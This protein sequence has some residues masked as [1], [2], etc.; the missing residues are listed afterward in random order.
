MGKVCQIDKKPAG[1]GQLLSAVDRE[2]EEQIRTTI[3]RRGFFKFLGLRAL[4]LGFGVSIFDTI[5]QSGAASQAAEKAEEDMQ[6]RLIMIGTVDFM[7]F[8]A[9]EIT[10][11]QEFYITTYSTVEP[12]ID[13]DKHRLRIEGLVGKPSVMTL[14]D[15]EALKDKEEFV[16]LQCIGN[17]VGGDAIGNALWEGVTL[18]KILDLARPGPGIVKAAF[19]CEDGYSDSIPYKLARSDDVFLAWRMNGEPLPRQHG[20]PLRLIVPGIYGMKNVKWLSK[21]E[22]VNYNFKGYWEK[23]GWSDEAVMPVKSQILMPMNGKSIPLGKYMVG[24]IAFGGRYGIS[25]VQV[26]VDGGHKWSEA[27]VKPPL[28]KWAWSL[29]EY[30]WTPERKGDYKI[31]VRGIDRSGK[32]QESAGLLGRITGSYPAGSKGIHQIDVTVM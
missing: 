14:K 2:R 27:H 18:R 20:Y 9:K 10:P 7:G 25:R 5:F 11:N 29:W 4:G 16:T 19:F 26:S 12:E 3:G 8:K 31:Q 1:S 15:L 13:P 21:I 28:S 24:G 30:D 22:L 17:P 6:H 32:V 23:R